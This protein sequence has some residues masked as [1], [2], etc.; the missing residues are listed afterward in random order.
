MVV[1]THIS[2]L[3]LI[4]KKRDRTTSTAYTTQPEQLEV[5]CELIGDTPFGRY[6]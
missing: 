4:E 5:V 3:L 6:T 1:G 2:R